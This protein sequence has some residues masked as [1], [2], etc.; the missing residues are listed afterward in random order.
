MDAL[1]GFLSGVGVSLIV[2]IVTNVLTRRRDRRKVVELLPF[3]IK[4][5][6]HLVHFFPMLRFPLLIIHFLLLS[7]VVTLVHCEAR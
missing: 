7:L 3:L 2:A 5:I 4:I 1:I 6:L